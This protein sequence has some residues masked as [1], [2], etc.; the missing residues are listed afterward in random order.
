MECKKKVTETASPCKSINVLS[1]VRFLMYQHPALSSLCDL[2]RS[3]VQRVQ[4]SGRVSCTSGD[5][6]GRSLRNPSVLQR[7]LAHPDSSP[8][9]SRRFPRMYTHGE[10]ASESIFMLTDTFNMCHPII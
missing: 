10:I 6:A 5:S 9:F 2:S 8:N 1:V 4:K 7:L 3:R